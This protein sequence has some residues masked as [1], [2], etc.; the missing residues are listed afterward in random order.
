MKPLMSK[1]RWLAANHSHGLVFAVSP[2]NR[3][4]LRGAT[5]RIGHR[6]SK[7][8]RG[9]A[10]KAGRISVGPIP[11][12]IVFVGV[13]DI[14]RYRAGYRWRDPFTGFAIPEEA[15]RCRKEIPFVA[16]VEMIRQSS[17][18]W[19]DRRMRRSGNDAM[20]CPRAAERVARGHRCTE[21]QYE[22]RIRFIHHGTPTGF[23]TSDPILG[24]LSRPPTL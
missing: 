8:G 12:D 16:S 22:D 20:G 13:I 19:T 5:G 18:R 23:A 24:R 14:A 9:A 3:Y 2:G 17:D 21:R 1:M 6:W 10:K 11:G 7:R 15:S 4:D